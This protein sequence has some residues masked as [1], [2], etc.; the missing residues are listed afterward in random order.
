MKIIKGNI[1]VHCSTKEEAMALF[2][3]LGKYHIRWNTFKHRNYIGYRVV[4]NLLSY[5]QI[6]SLIQD[7]YKIIEFEELIK[8]EKSFKILY[9]LQEKI[10]DFLIGK[11]RC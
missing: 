8:E 2:K 3:E 9:K 4:G 1:A 6:D 10:K 5:A 11:T 7:G